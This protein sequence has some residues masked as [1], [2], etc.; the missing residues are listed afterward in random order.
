MEP[1]RSLLQRTHLRPHW[2]GTK[3]NPPAPRGNQVLWRGPGKILDCGL[4]CGAKRA[5]SGI[6]SVDVKNDNADKERKP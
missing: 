2:N 3:P 4:S 5:P 1:P 6:M